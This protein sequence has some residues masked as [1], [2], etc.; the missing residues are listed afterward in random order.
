MLLI[1][2]L[3]FPSSGFS[4]GKATSKK[5]QTKSHVT[6]SIKA[7]TDSVKASTKIQKPNQIDAEIA[8]SAQDSIVLLGN[9]TGFLHGKSD[10]KY[11]NIELKADFVRVR[12]DSSLVFAHGKLDSIGR[13]VDD[14][15]FTESKA[16]YTSKELTYNLKTKKGYI[17]QAVTKQGEGYVISDK[18]KKTDDDVLCIANGKYTTC[19]NH[20][21]P[22]FYLDLTRG[23]VRT[24]KNIVTGPAYLVV[25]D[26]PLPIAI[27]FGFFPFTDKYSSGIIMPTFST[28]KVYRH[29][30]LPLYFSRSNPA[31]LYHFRCNSRF[32]FNSYRCNL[33][34]RFNIQ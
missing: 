24:G 15:V 9:G 20:E 14:P 12:M 7:S 10:V 33:F 32:C 18:T 8:Y 34:Q 4:Q 25:E 26:V 23:K 1:L 2:W 21:H 31:F 29:T 27:P 13:R 19:D 6:D 11:K 3:A 16:E 30:F 22:D 28:R 17:R 5:S